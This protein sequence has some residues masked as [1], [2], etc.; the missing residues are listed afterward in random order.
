MSPM[1]AS[2]YTFRSPSE[3]GAVTDSGNTRKNSP[4]VA[5]GWMADGVSDAA[6]P[7]V[8][9][10]SAEQSTREQSTRPPKP[11][12]VAVRNGAVRSGDAARSAVRS[13]SDVSAIDDSDVVFRTA[14]R[15]G[16][17]RRGDA[18]RNAVRSGAVRSGDAA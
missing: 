10:D 15:S 9:V 7:T 12:A 6:S 17:V 3:N 16:A 13:G 5:P 1:V 4:T 14:V 11:S 18:S 8:C 2:P